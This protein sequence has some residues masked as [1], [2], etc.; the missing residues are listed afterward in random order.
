MLNTLFLLTILSLVASY[1]TYAYELYSLLLQMDNALWVVNTEGDPV[2]RLIG[3]TAL[4]AQ[5]RAWEM[6]KQLSSLIRLAK[7]LPKSLWILPTAIMVSDI[8]TE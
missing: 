7:R 6:R 4:S 1:K 2:L 5:Q 3:G 8:S